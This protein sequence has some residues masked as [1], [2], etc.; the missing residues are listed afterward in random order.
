MVMG[1]GFPPFRGGLLRY[2]DDRG[3][4]E[5]L[6][7]VEGF[8]SEVGSRFQP[9]ALLVELARAGETFHGAFAAGSA[10]SQPVKKGRG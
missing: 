6:A 1:T 2:A 5:V 8:A 10:D 4:G 7:V 9:S 3:L